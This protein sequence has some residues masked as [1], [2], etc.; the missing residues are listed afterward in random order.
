MLTDIPRNPDPTPFKGKGQHTQSLGAICSLNRWPELA[1]F[2]TRSIDARARRAEI[3]RARQRLKALGREMV[4]DFRRT[5]PRAPFYLCRSPDRANT[6]LRWRFASPRRAMARSELGDPELS[7]LLAA[8]PQD[9]RNDIL[10][11]EEYRTN[12]NYLFALLTYECGRLDDHV[13]R[14]EVLRQ[15]RRPRH[16]NPPAT[17]PR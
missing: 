7:Q 11:Y 2:F 17:A 9:A 12:L 3:E 5:H 14:L 4:E 8:L 15:L 13:Q 10:R 16:S 6:F 1:Q